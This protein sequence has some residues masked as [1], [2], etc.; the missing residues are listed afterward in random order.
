MRNANNNR[1]HE[2]IAL[3]NIKP[4][5]EELNRIGNPEMPGYAK[6]CHSCTT[7]PLVGCK[8]SSMDMSDMFP[9]LKWS[10]LRI[11]SKSRHSSSSAFCFQVLLF[12]WTSHDT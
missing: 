5:K 12:P 6:I 2:S 1:Y 8:R 10:C 4:P 3:H 9:Y 7:Q 11:E